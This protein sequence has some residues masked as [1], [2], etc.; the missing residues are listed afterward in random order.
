MSATPSL[1]LFGGA[2]NL[3]EFSLEL[4]WGGSLNHFVFPNLTTFKLVT[5]LM[6]GLTTSHLLAF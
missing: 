1:S 5:P 6:C 3:K 2:V 4:E